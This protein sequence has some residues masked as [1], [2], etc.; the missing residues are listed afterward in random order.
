MKA[1]RDNGTSVK[2]SR[3]SRWL[4]GWQAGLI[5]V[6]IG[7]LVVSI[8]IPRP[9]LPQEI[10]SPRPNWAKLGEVARQ[11]SRLATLAEQEPLP[12]EVRQVGES[13]RSFGLA[14]AA[15]DAASTQR[16]Q[17]LLQQQI[18]AVREPDLLL[19]L[20]AWQTQD[21]LKEVAAFETT[22]NE[23]QGLR[24]LGGE[25]V[26]IAQQAGWLV[27]RGSGYH[28]LIDDF[29]RQ[30]LF[31]KRWNEI[32]HLQRAPFLL[33]IDEERVFYA[34]LFRFP[35]HHSWHPDP[36][37]RC[38]SANEQLLKK[39]TAFGAIDPSY[40]TDY[41]RGV[42]LLRLDRPQLAV[43]PLAQFLDNNPDGPYTLHARNA[44]RFAQ[45]QL[46]PP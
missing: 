20:R 28:W 2:T 38:Q 44:L 46:L 10:P 22:G 11:D 45:N 37:R 42:L 4:D 26:R 41:A 24:E 3:A 13:F 6:A 43:E 21:F 19:R 1:S 8:V 17:L 25:I 9:R 29:T 36:L 16:I 18:A 15:G 14:V 39:V 33:S 5:V 7:V 30:V 27:P 23:S 32:L 40:P 35:G 12:F 34:F 31:R